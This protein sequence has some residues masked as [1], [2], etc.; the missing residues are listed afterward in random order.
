MPTT[1][2]QLLTCW[3]GDAQVLRKRGCERDAQF[4]ESL[5][6]E[7]ED[8]L[9]VATTEVLNLQQAATESG[10][11]QDHLRRLIRDGR[12]PNAGRTRAPRVR[13]GDLPRKAGRFDDQQ[14]TGY[15]PVADARQVAARRAHGGEP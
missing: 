7:L 6:L 13:R 8:A 3:R 9:R 14:T 12:L 4:L 15:D 10:Y 5:A 11:S 1:P 2:E